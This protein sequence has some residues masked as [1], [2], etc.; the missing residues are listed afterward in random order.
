MARAKSSP[1]SVKAKRL[2]LPIARRPVFESL[3]DGVSVGYRRNDGAGAWVARRSDG[4]GGKHEG[5]IGTA[6]DYADADGVSVLSYAQA[7]AAAFEWAKADAAKTAKGSVPAAPLTLEKAIERYEGDLKVRGGDTGNVGRLRAHL[8]ERLLKMAVPDLTVGD[9]KEWRDG[10]TETLAAASVNRTMTPLKAALNAAADAD[11]GNTITSRAPWEIGLKTLADAEEAHNI[12]LSAAVVAK[13]VK[14]AYAQSEAF[15]LLVEVLAVTG[16]RS[17]QVA[18]IRVE[19]LQNGGTDPRLHVP[20]SAKGK[21]QK[22]VRSTPVPIPTTLAK[23]L[24][25]S[26][27]GRA[28]SAPLLTKPTGGVWAKSDH[29]RPFA[30][31]VK[32]AGLRAEEIAPH[33]FNDLTIYALR[34]SAIVRQIIAGVPLRIVAALAD[35]SAVMIERT[36]SKYIAHH[37]DA[38]ARG[39]LLDLGETVAVP[40][41]PVPA[42]PARPPFEGRCR[43][44]HDYAEFP[45]YTNKAGAVVC[46]ECG[47]QRTARN[48]DARRQ[49]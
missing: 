25:S 40:T 27:E 38:L 31:A 11:Q 37:A 13:I 45:P 18:R 23:R 47:R 34:H 36:Y 41:P 29:T 35:T 8:P 9:L 22:K 19:D 48:K 4:K 16:S 28:P 24:K 43:H 5:R 3:G 1:L 21:G 39:A 6:D 14:A 15:G 26:C 12:I 30:R 42:K 10:L 20:T 33:S 32:A 2:A 44:G 7:T 46:A 49:A 17:S